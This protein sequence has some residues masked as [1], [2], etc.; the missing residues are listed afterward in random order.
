MVSPSCRTPTVKG[1]DCGLTPSR[2]PNVPIT[3]YKCWRYQD[4]VLEVTHTQKYMICKIS[5]TAIGY[6]HLMDNG[7]LQKEMGLMLSA[8]ATTVGMALCHV[9]CVAKINRTSSTCF[10]WSRT[11]TQ[12]SLSS[13]DV[14]VYSHV[15]IDVWGVLHRIHVAQRV[16]EGFTNLQQMINSPFPPKNVMRPL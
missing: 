14:S 11:S 15:S 1:S 12:K 16:N 5:F 3:L 9:E 2:Q 13:L 7:T 10:A 8:M 6:M 4:T